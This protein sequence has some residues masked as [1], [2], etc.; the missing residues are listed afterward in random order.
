[1]GNADFVWSYL[2]KLNRLP[3]AYTAY[4]MLMRAYLR[5]GQIVTLKRGPAAGLLWEHHQCYQPWMA[6][7]T[8]E[9]QVA[10]F[11]FQRL[12]AGQVFYDIGAN[13]GYFTLIG[14][15]KVGETGTVIAFDPVPENVRTIRRQ[16]EL[17]GLEACCEVAPLAVSSHAGSATL[18]LPG[19]NANAHLADVDAPHVTDETGSSILVECVTLD[20]FVLQHRSP[21]LIKMDIE[22]AEVE[23]LKGA[24]GLLRSKDAPEWLITAHSDALAEEVKSILV[25]AGYRIGDF[26]HMMHGIPQRQHAKG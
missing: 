18:T 22:G 2:R 11:L 1:M 9:P 24:T 10:D 3:G 13:A 26:S 15:K 12:D 23:A 17:N 25:A 4:S 5:D 19:R 8:Y 7:G 6:I 14:A 21:D 16:V 20:E